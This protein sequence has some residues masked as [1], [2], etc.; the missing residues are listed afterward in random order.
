MH[1][2]TLSPSR[3]V[4]A[5]RAAVARLGLSTTPLLRIYEV[6]MAHALPRDEVEGGLLVDDSAGRGGGGGGGGDARSDS[7][8]DSVAF[9][10][11]C[12]AIYASAPRAAGDESAPPQERARMQARLFFALDLNR[13]GVV[14][15]PELIAALL[16][17]LPA[18]NA[19]ERIGVAFAA[20][21]ANEDG[22]LSRGELA[23][24]LTAMCTVAQR[25]SLPP[26]R[27]A[28]AAAAAA[29]GDEGAAERGRLM[30]ADAFSSIGDPALMT[31]AR[32]SDVFIGSMPQP[33]SES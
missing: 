19:F 26:P 24:F 28:G 18:S 4:D 13:D 20:F 3:E 29:A 17:L 9:A 14:S 30:A 22:A 1:L 10:A 2:P 33:A 27:G 32:F 31:L 23:T 12:E 16:V 15:F 6:C 21:D 7:V 5:W 8:L 25:F 11:A